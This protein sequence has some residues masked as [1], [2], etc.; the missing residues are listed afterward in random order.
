[1]FD[2]ELLSGKTLYQLQGERIKKLL[3]I[4]KAKYPD[5]NPV[6][7]WYIMTSDATNEIS[8]DYFKK[9]NYYGLDPKTVIFFNQ[10]SL[11]CMSD[12]DGKILLETKSSVALAPNGNGG[13]Y[14]S[15]KREGV[16]KH[17]QDNNVQYV[18]CLSLSNH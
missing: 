2:M 1:M 7:Q 10:E 13:L 18:N 4:A 11:P 15:L 6:I 14:T 12:P 3:Q 5:S 9:H 8:E 17:M 16:L